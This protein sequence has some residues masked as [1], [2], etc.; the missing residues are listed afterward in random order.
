MRP[1]YFSCEEYFQS[2]NHVIQYMT[3][4]ASAVVDFSKVKD[5]YVPALETIECIKD[6]NSKIA[7]GHLTQ[8]PQEQ[9]AIVIL[10]LLLTRLIL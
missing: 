8:L 6:L 1:L 9:L 5:V 10:E 2:P 7:L 4:L 3:A